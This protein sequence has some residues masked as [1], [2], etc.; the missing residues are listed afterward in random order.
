[1]KFDTNVI[2]RGFHTNVLRA[3]KQSP[4]IFF[5]VGMLGSITSTVLACRATLQLPGILDNMKKDIV[6]LNEVQEIVSNSGEDIVTPYTQDEYRR[7]LAYIYGKGAL[8]ITKLYA[9][10]F[11]IGA[12]SIGLLTKSHVDLTKRNTALMAAYAVV[13]KAYEDYR[14]RVK[15]ILG[16]EGELDVYHG[17]TSEKVDKRIQQIVDPNKMSP[18]ARFFD[19]Y[20][21]NWTKDPE[22]NRI[23][24]Q[25]QQNYLNQKLLAHGY[26]FLNEAYEAL[27]IERS[28]QGQVVGWVL[29]DDGLRDN[30]IDFGIFEAR[31]AKF[32]NG[33]ETSILLDF[34]VDGVI[35]DLI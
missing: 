6:R 30:Y 26:V 4:H 17:V 32:V 29:R 33:V 25:C 24:V 23:F 18:Y 34:N 31:N 21:P 1:M 27:G 15:D 10:S 9:P 16:E 35:F 3:K 28:S 11:V 2:R 7:Q 5:G 13:Q 14:E 8:E 12:T 22:I 20:T 19:E